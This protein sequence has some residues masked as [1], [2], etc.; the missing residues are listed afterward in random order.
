M[1]PAPGRALY[2]ALQAL[3]IGGAAYWLGVLPFVSDEAVRG[4]IHY[5]PLFIAA[6]TWWAI[7][8][9]WVQG[10]PSSAILWR[11]PWV[12]GVMGFFVLVPTWAALSF[13]RMQE[14]GAWLVLMIVAVVA[15][16]DIGGYFVGRSFGRHKLA[17]NVSPGKTW[18][19]FSGAWSRIS[20]WRWRSGC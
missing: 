20:V 9:L 8:L 14:Q 6:C 10:Y 15:A 17:P 11:H 18:E 19:G 1:Y 13:V 12:R 2:V 7:A 3:V 5:R 4:H 16:A